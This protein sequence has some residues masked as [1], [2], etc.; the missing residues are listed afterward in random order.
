[1]LADAQPER[2]GLVLEGYGVAD[3][4]KDSVRQYR[5]IFASRR[6]DHPFLREDDTEFLRQIGVFKHDRVRNVDGLTLGGLLMLGR[7]D[8]IRDRYPQWHLSYRERAAQPAGAR[9]TDRLSADGTWNAN[10]FEFYGRVIGKLHEGLKV[11]FALDAAQFRR[12]DTPAHAAIREALVNTL[13]HADYEGGG[14]IRIVR[15]PAGYELTNPGLLLVSAEPVWRGGVSEPRNPVLQRLFGLLYLGEREGSGGP[16]IRQAWAQQHWRTPALREDIEHSETHLLLSQVRLFPPD[17][18]AE[19][20]KTVGG[21]FD[22]LDEVGRIALVT[23]AVESGVTHARL[24]ELTG[25]HSRDVTL[26]LQ[27]LVRKGLLISKGSPRAKTYTLAVDTKD[28]ATGQLHFGQPGSEETSDESSPGSEETFDESSPGS[29]E[30]AAGEPR[31]WAPRQQQLEGVL[32]FCAGQWRTLSEIAKAV[33]RTENTV[34]TTYLPPLLARGLL[35]RRHPASPR[36][37]HQAYRT[38]GEPTT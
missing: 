9:W 22:A 19:L 18:V 25:A 15:E 10:V 1:M 27:E 24:C 33:G 6:P 21:G 37:P 16:A 29:E 3:L 11:P 30:K 12:D 23:A 36:H 35:E 20:R 2:D 5:N 34:R 8:A 31:G 38:T 4:A 14:G 26:R 7:E 13:V 17:A 28:S 32:T